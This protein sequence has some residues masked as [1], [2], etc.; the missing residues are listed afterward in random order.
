MT[1]AEAESGGETASLSGAP[2]TEDDEGCKLDS[3]AEAE[4]PDSG[5]EAAEADEDDEGE[6]SGSG[7]KAAIEAK[8]AAESKRSTPAATS[9]QL[10]AV[11]RAV[12]E[13]TPAEGLAELAVG[14][15]DD[16][17]LEAD[18][19]VVTIGDLQAFAAAEGPSAE[20]RAGIVAEALLLPLR[21]RW[22]GERSASLGRGASA[23]ER[24]DAAVAFVARHM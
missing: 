9:A 20:R 7:A 18:E 22:R 24:I 23:K 2:A 21:R 11:L 16:E 3:A 15:L 5:G 8:I 12:I 6:A 1:R 4:K 14:G 13:K 19:R 17:R 10:L